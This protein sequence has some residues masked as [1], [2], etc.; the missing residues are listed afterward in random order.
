MPK[1]PVDLLYQLTVTDAG[2]LTDTTYLEVNVRYPADRPSLGLTRRMSLGMQPGQTLSRV[3]PAATGGDGALTYTLTP[4]APGVMAFDAATRQVTFTPTAAGTWDFD[5][6]VTDRDEDADTITVSLR[7]D[8]AAAT[9]PRFADGAAIADLR[10]YAGRD[11]GPRAATV[12]LAPLPAATGGDGDLAYTLEPAVPGLS[13]DPHTRRI[14]GTPTTAGSYAMTYRAVDSDADTGDADSAALTFTIEVVANTAP[15]ALFAGRTLDLAV[16]IP[17]TDWRL[18]LLTYPYGVDLRGYFFDADGDDLVFTADTLP[19]GV[20]V[21]TCTAYRWAHCLIPIKEGTWT[22]VITATDQNG[23]TATQTI[24]LTGKP[25]NRPPVVVEDQVD[26]QSSLLYGFRLGN[27]PAP[28]LAKTSSS[29]RLL[30]FDDPDSDTLTLRAVSSDPR[31]QTRINDIRKFSDYGYIGSSYGWTRFQIQVFVR[32]EAAQVHIP[33]F[34]ATVTMTVTDAYGG[35]VSVEHSGHGPQSS[36]VGGHSG[37]PAGRHR[38]ELRRRDGGGPE[39][40]GGQGDRSAAPAFG[41]GRHASAELHAHPCGAGADVRCRHAHAVGHADH[42]RGRH[43]HDLR[44]HGRPLSGAHGH[45]GLQHHHHR[46]R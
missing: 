6:T 12:P 4:A 22:L 5:Y 20:H 21:S 9:A 10:L 16:K 41:H 1:H 45:A 14:T 17:A 44:G 35:S 46:R 19:E 36:V 29:T 33:S 2:G 38:A 25:A 37:R 15:V 32:P 39:L 28:G 18:P 42:R 7:V 30:V 27:H 8:A 34:G 11:A 31:L 13:L 23:A 26:N 3:L 43:G 40:A 24:R